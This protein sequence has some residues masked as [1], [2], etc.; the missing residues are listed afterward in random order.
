ML[1]APTRRRGPSHLHGTRPGAEMRRSDVSIVAC[2]A[3]NAGG[4]VLKY[5]IMSHAHRPQWSAQ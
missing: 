2:A 1:P 3:Q 5:P 4:P